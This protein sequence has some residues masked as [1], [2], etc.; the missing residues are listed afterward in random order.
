VRGTTGDRILPALY[1]DN[2]VS[3][4]PGETK[5]VEIEVNAA[6]ARGEDP[7][8]AVE[9]FNVSGVAERR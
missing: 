4:M 9:G 5:R 6:D 1:S 2:Y 8:V 7:R 3:I